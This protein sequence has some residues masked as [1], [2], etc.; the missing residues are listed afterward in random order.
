LRRLAYPIVR[1]LLGRLGD[2]RIVGDDDNVWWR[3]QFDRYSFL[4]DHLGDYIELGCGPYTNT[5]LILR[6]R[7]ANRVV[8]SDPLAGH[9]LGFRDRWLSRAARS[10]L[11]SVDTHPIERLP[12]PS[13]SFDTVVLINVLDHVQDLDRCLETATNLLRAGGW[14]VLGQDIAKVADTTGYEWYEEGHPH[15]VTLDQVRPHLAS[16][17]T[18][19]ESLV[20]P[21]DDRLQEVVLVYAGRRRA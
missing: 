3:E 6:G 4:P 17:R 18:E 5:R 19:Y 1:P 14:L 21:R 2:R 7:T 10:G 11:V 9:Y 12:L 20:P 16:F 13:G 15:R 8:C